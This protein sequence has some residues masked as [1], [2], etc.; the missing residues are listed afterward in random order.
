MRRWALLLDLPTKRLLLAAARAAA[1]RVG[2]ANALSS[3]VLDKSSIGGRGDAASILC[4]EFFAVMPTASNER[5]PTARMKES[6]I[7]FLFLPRIA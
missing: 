6:T 1:G 3:A 7:Q 5:K 2:G 4:I